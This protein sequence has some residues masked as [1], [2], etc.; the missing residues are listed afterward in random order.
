MTKTMKIKVQPKDIDKEYI[1]VEYEPIG[2]ARHMDITDGMVDLLKLAETKYGKYITG[3]S[4]DGKFYSIALNEEGQAL[5]DEEHKQICE[6]MRN[7]PYCD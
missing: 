5:W 7:N 2:I 4:C 6:F 3:L 1:Y